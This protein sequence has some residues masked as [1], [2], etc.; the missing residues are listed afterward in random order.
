MSRPDQRLR[1]SP[2]DS[3]DGQSI[4]SRTSRGASSSFAAGMSSDSSSMSSV[5]SGGNSVDMEE[6][7][8]TK[9]K[10]KEDWNEYIEDKVKDVAKDRLWGKVKF[11]DDDDLAKVEPGRRG[12]PLDICLKELGK[13]SYNRVQQ[14]KFWNTYGKTVKKTLGARRCDTVS[15]MKKSI[16]SCKY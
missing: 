2:L 9:H 1:V 13:T 14:I 11:C 5:S 16:I 6:Y 15:A 10:L 3:S 12:S 7:N 8:A 4:T